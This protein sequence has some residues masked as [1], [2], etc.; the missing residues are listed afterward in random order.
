MA[1]GS[2]INVPD[3]PRVPVWRLAGGALG[4]GGVC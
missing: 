1:Q 3:L 4:R 2:V